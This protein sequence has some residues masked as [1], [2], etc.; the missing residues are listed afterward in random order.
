LVI[1]YIVITKELM[2]IITKNYKTPKIK[3]TY[4]TKNGF[5]SLHVESFFIYC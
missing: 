4:K 3:Q 2:R 1:D 5:K